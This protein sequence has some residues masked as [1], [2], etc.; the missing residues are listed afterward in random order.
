M[1]LTSSAFVKPYCSLWKV[2][3]TL[4]HKLDFADETFVEFS[5]F[6]QDRIVGTKGYQATVSRNLCVFV[7]W[8]TVEGPLRGKANFDWR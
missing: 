4:E 5:R 3:E 7:L 2:G 8:G 1:L 6:P